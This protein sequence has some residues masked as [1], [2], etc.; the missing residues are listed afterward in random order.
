M[1]NQHRCITVKLFYEDYERKLGDGYFPQTERDKNMD[2]ET[3]ETFFLTHDGRWIQQSLGGV[4][5]NKMDYLV[6]RIGLD[7][8]AAIKGL[9][10]DCGIKLLSMLNNESEAIQIQNGISKDDVLQGTMIFNT[11]NKQ[12]HPKNNCYPLVD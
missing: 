2:R 12:L 10:G 7:E 5:N 4:D 11:L 8:Y 3:S 9:D 1:A 6:T